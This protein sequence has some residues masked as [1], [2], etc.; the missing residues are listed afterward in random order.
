MLHSVDYTSSSCLPILLLRCCSSPLMR[1]YNTSWFS[2]PA[3]IYRLIHHSREVKKATLTGHQISFA[4]KLSTVNQFLE[5]KYLVSLNPILYLCETS[6]DLWFNGKSGEVCSN[7]PLSFSPCWFRSKVES[8][9]FDILFCVSGIC[10][11]ASPLHKMV[12]VMASHSTLISSICQV[13]VITLFYWVLTRHPYIDIPK[14]MLYGTREI[15]PSV[16]YI[17]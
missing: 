8:L 9:E 14:I 2:L 17:G 4:W 12:K 10:G 3:H 13:P 6:Q 1:Q 11:E 15:V 16:T 7:K 5:S